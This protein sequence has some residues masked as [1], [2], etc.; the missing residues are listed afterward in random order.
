MLSTKAFVLNMLPLYLMVIIGFL[1]RKRGIL[2]AYV[3]EA[4]A[5]LL[6]Y[7]TLPLLILYSLNTSMTRAMLIEFTWLVTMSIF[8]IVSSALFASFL[9]KKADLPGHQ[10]TV[11][12]SLI[13]FGNQGFIGVSIIY[14]IMGETGIMYVTFFN[15]CYLFF[16]WAYGIYIFTKKN[17]VADWKQVFF[18][19]GVVS[20]LLGLSI[21]F[22]PLHWPEPFLRT[23]EMI[24]KMT[25]PLSMLLIGCLLA[26]MKKTQVK[27]YLRNQY[28]WSAAVTRLCIIPMFLFVFLLFG[29]PYPLFVIAVITSAMPSA[30]TVSVYAQKFGGD[31]SFS[32]VGVMLTTILCLFTIPLLYTLLL[33]LSQYD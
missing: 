23:F 9:R 14:I 7:V 5:Q 21:M 26:D 16:I 1:S 25:I 31:V 27:S 30:S 24:G 33:W 4:M 32:T 18:N 6:L 3:K 20:T 17:N 12:E 28:I 10:K 2:T 22:S 11:Y 15:V 29:V 8:M 13:I 19:P